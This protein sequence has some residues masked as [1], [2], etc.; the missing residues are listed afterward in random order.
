MAE[1][2]NEHFNSGFTNKNINA[3]PLKENRFKSIDS[4]YHGELIVTANM[5]TD[6]T[7]Q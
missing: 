4:E 1:D 6:Q 5:V 7:P 3:V 2:L